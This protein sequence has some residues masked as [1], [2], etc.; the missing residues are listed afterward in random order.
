[1]AR[2][3]RRVPPTRTS[4]A[5]GCHR[6]S[7]RARRGAPRAHQR[8]QPLLARARRSSPAAADGRRPLQRGS[9]LR[10]SAG[11]VRAGS[12]THPEPGRRGAR[13]HPPRAA[14]CWCSAS[15]ARPGFRWLDFS[16]PPSRA[17]AAWGGQ[18]RFIYLDLHMHEAVLTAVEV[19]ERARRER[20][21]S[22]PQ[23]GRTAFIDRWMKAR[24]ASRSSHARVSIRCTRLASSRTC[25]KRCPAG[26]RSWS[27]TT[28]WTRR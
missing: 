12:H 13:P 2:S 7:D 20:V 18:G 9:R 15:R 24:L 23:A 28:G 3:R 16:I 27:P 21:E 11:S 14:A 10:A 17:A 5:Q 4:P 19:G 26:S 1:M 25:S 6:G 22:V 8:H